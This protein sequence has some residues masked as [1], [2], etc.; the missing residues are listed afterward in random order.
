MQPVYQGFIFPTITSPLPEATLV[1]VGVSTN[2]LLNVSFPQP[3]NAPSDLPDG[4]GPDTRH[5]HSCRSHVPWEW[6]SDTLD[7]EK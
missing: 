3:E 5:P 4:L 7:N 6:V 2:N 1:T